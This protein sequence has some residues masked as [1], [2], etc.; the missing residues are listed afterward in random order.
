MKQLFVLN[1]STSNRGCE[2]ILLS[3][4]DILN[5]AFPGS[6][7][8]NSSFTDVRTGK[9]PYL[10]LPNLE[11]ACH[12]SLRSLAGMRWQIAKRLQGRQFNFEQFLPRADTVWSLGGDNYSMD[13]DSAQIYFDANE[14]ILAAGKKLIIWGASI[15]PFDKDPSLERFASKH[16]KR[17]HKIVVR[18]TRSKA[19]LEGMGVR[20]NVVLLPDPAFSL[21]AAEV[22]L[23]LAVEQMLEAGAIGINLSP[24]LARYRR[25][26]GQWVDEAASWVTA[27]LDNTDSP[28]LL[29]PHVMQPGNDDE[30]FLAEVQARIKASPERLQ[31]LSGYGL[32]SRQL[33]YVIA[34]LRCLIGARTHATIAA[35]S[36]NVPTLS[37]GY[38][39]KARG[40]NEDIFGNDRWVVDHLTLDASS[41][42]EKT[43][44]LLG[45]E[46]QIRQHLALK[47]RSYRMTN[48]AV[49]ALFD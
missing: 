3:T 16:L 32:S 6:T 37:I 5:S 14:R 12:P 4:Y 19:Y 26:T 21:E 47:N 43:L 31:L 27:V 13:Y 46:T 36:K 40:I 44:E 11:H 15:G 7:Y 30:A 8:I 33:K 34:R 28:V 18:E 9:T 35:L 48:T 39:V 22:E 42:V 20:D 2:A 45:A 1:A 25:A 29:I 38:S 23:P 24:L 49:R 41:F 17:V 10:Q